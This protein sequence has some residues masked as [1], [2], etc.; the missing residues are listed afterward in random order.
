ME[1]TLRPRSIRL[2]SAVPL[3]LL[4]PL[5]LLASAQEPAGPAPRRGAR[6]AAE[7]ATAGSGTA[8]DPWTGWEAAVC[9]GCQTYFSAGWYATG[10]GVDLGLTLANQ[11]GRTSITGEGFESTTI[12]GTAD[13]TL[14]RV[15]GLR[16]GPPATGQVYLDGLGFTTNVTHTRPSG[17]V[18][19]ENLDSQWG[20]RNLSIRNLGADGKTSHD[21]AKGIRFLDCQNGNVENLYVRAHMSLARNFAVGVEV[22]AD[23]GNQRGNLQFVGGQVNHAQTGVR[24]HT[25]GGNSINNC[26]FFGTKFVHGPVDVPGSVGIDLGPQADQT[27]LFNVHVEGF[28]TG[29]RIDGADS[30]QVIGGLVSRAAHPREARGTAI[31]IGLRHPTDGVFLSAPRLEGCYDGIVVGPRQNRRVYYFRGRTGSIAHEEWVD[32]STCT[33]DCPVRFL[34]SH[35]IAGPYRIP[36]GDARPSV[37]RGDLYRTANSRPTTVTAFPDGV[38]GQ[39][40]RIVFD[41]A[42]TTVRNAGSLALA[43]PFVSTAGSTLTLARVEGRWYEMAR[44]VRPPSPASP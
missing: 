8:D 40:I 16:G 25:T 9:D 13:V 1:E 22:T 17:M 7:E 14:L 11:P 33:L 18:S 31:E 30:T 36:D 29:I 37:A 4:G 10:K 19:L 43:G 6:L 3:A 2:R 38:E 26:S 44:T 34:G 5:L 27:G 28:E 41:D 20:V 15:R 24:L 21:V 39:V 32:R 35:A 12:V 42:K 23:D